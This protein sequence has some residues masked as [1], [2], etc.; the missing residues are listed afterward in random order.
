MAYNITNLST[1]STVKK[2]IFFAAIIVCLV[3]INNLARSIY[4]LWNKQDLIVNANNDLKKEKEENLKLKQEFVRVKNTN[5]IEEEARDKL[6]LVKPGES[7]VILPSNIG[8][9]SKKEIV[10][11][12][13][14]PNWQ[15][16]VNRFLGD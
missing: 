13:E 4:D 2:I 11:K 10:V 15:K 5:F 12:D 14:S 9:D 8:E 16:W 3:V 7:G 1:T 6:F